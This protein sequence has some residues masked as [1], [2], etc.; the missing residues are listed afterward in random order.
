MDTNE[1][2][3]FWKEMHKPLKKQ[4]EIDIAARKFYFHF[5]GRGK[6]S[7]VRVQSA[8]KLAFRMNEAGIPRRIIESMLFQALVSS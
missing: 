1:V 5:I 7:E 3:A 2:K 8:P 4:N 6:I